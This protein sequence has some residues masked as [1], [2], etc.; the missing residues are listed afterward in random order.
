LK[1]GKNG[2]LNL[3]EGIHADNKDCIYFKNDLVWID[4]R[5]RELTMGFPI[6]KE[7]DLI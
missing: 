2:N 3:P 6:K 1:N 5:I 4:L 7:F